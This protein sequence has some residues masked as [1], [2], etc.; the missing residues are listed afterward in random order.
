MLKIL[1][2]DALEIVIVAVEVE[3]EA[4]ERRLPHFHFSL[5]HEN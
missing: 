1:V 3:E 4:A 5:S 2:V